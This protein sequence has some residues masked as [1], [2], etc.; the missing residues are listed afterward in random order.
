MNRPKSRQPLGQ[1]Q[2]N[3]STHAGNDPSRQRPSTSVT[4]ARY[5]TGSGICRPQILQTA[6]AVLNAQQ[7]QNTRQQPSSSVV[8]AQQGQTSRQN[9]SAETPVS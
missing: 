8:T 9:Y 7:G 2:S 3:T 5:S 1:S 6:A 4:N